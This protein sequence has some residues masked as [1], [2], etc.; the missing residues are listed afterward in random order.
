MLPKYK[1]LSLDAHHTHESWEL[2]GTGD[3]PLTPAFGEG[4]VEEGGALNLRLAWST[5]GDPVFVCF[6]A[7]HS[8]VNLEP[9]CWRAETCGSWGSCWLAGLVNPEHEGSGP[10]ERPYLRN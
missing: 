8:D 5:Q 10:T 9:W 6:K 1:D 2:L 7:E 4:G 3:T